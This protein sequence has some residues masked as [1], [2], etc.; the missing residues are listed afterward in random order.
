MFK[1]FRCWH[2]YVMDCCGGHL[3]INMA[4]MYSSSMSNAMG[5]EFDMNLLIINY[6]C[7]D[8]DVFG[9]N[10]YTIRQ[11]RGIIILV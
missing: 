8:V 6:I 3:K 11:I 9:K 10:I 4:A 2:M 7:T 5:T 1:L